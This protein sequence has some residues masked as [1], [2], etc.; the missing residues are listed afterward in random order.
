MADREIYPRHVKILWTFSG[1]ICAICNKA[2]I[3]E[4]ND[5]DKYTIGEMA[6]IF[7]ENKTAARYDETIPDDFVRSYK[8]H[9]VL[10]ASCHTIIDKNETDYPEERLF[11]I[12][13]AHEM[14]VLN[15]IKSTLSSVSFAELEVI[16]KYLQSQPVN[17]DNLN[18]ITPAEKI[19]K[20]SL[21][22]ETDTLIKIG[23]MKRYDVSD[24]LN[25]NPDIEF[26]DRLRAGI[27]E[28]YTQLKDQGYTAD[29]LFHE[30]LIF[31]SRGNHDIRMQSAA[32]AVLSYYFEICDIFES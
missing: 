30:L 24:Y 21:S 17:N 20:N 11:K 18:L 9:L 5:G 16:V 29:E 28:K 12:K 8:N 2:V 10:C 15:S 22:V 4:K 7:G 14:S 26:S 13:K 23:L 27:I 6:H 25:N 1:G 31:A 3:L 19:Q 32:L